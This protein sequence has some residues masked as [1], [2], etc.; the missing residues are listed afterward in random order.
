MSRFLF[1]GLVTFF[2]TDGASAGGC[3]VAPWH[4]VFGQQTNASMTVGSGEICITQLSS[5]ASHSGIAIHAM[6]IRSS[7]N[8]G[9]VSVVGLGL[10][11]HAKSNYTGPDSFVFEVVGAHQKLATVQVRI[12]VSSAPDAEDVSYRLKE[13]T[14]WLVEN[15]GPDKAKGIVYFIRGF[16]R[17]SP[18]IDEYRGV[19]FFI[20]TLHDQGWDIVAAKYPY[21]PNYTERAANVAPLAASQLRQRAKGLRAQGYKKVVII[22]QSWGAW[23]TMLA[24]DDNEFAADAIVLLVPATWGTRIVSGR[25]NYFFQ[26]NRTEFGPLL[27]DVKRPVA[28]ILFAGDEYDPGG[29]GQ[30]AKDIFRRHNISNL[31]IDNPPG[32]KGHYAAWLPVFDFVFG[33]CVSSFIESPVT[34]Q[35]SLPSL[36]DADFRSIVQ[37]DQIKDFDSRKISSVD[38]LAGRTFVIYRTGS[39][40]VHADFSRGQSSHTLKASG[41]VDERFSFSSGRFCLL[42]ECFDLVRWDERHLVG[43]DSI[44][45]NARSWWIRE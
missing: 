13:A 30:I 44:T 41:A 2:M 21:R 36:D 33:S 29:R 15:R 38:E 39:G 14:P 22:G 20:K 3:S 18:V 17:F 7:P 16:D 19:H 34:A 12:I 40:P 27:A 37:R 42:S 10:K 26:L 24:A 9:E 43:F 31:L 4:Y 25:L 5:A 1:A 23:S 45:G 32:F 8:N 6:R 11:Y 35:C 28:L